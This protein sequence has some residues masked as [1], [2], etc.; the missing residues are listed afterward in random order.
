[1]RSSWVSRGEQESDLRCCA[2]HVV[3]L[4]CA[5]RRSIHHLGTLAPPWSRLRVPRLSDPVGL[6]RD[7][8]IAARPLAGAALS[9]V[10]AGTTPPP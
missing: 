10:V 2:R 5:S 1:M 9:S 8:P 6:A 4:P 3:P 7:R